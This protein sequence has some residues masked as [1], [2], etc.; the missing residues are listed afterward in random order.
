MTTPPRPP[1]V[2]DGRDPRIAALLQVGPLDEVTRARLVRTALAG[3]DFEEPVPGTQPA[4]ESTPEHTPGRR[5]IV[6]ILSAAAALIVVLVVG[7]A[8]LVPWESDDP[9]PTALDVPSDSAKRTAP[10]VPAAGGSVDV[11]EG[12]VPFESTASGARIS[13][14]DS[15]TLPSL[16]DLGDVSN[17]TRLT[18]AVS[19]RLARP[20]DSTTVTIEGCVTSVAR[21]LGTPVAVGTGTIDGR[22]AVVVVAE[23]P[24]GTTAAVAVR[25]RSCGQAVSAVLP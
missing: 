9:R 21:A 4:P 18:R 5:P 3:A 11:Q 22:R 12:S 14:P 20:D 24:D 16:G 15:L 2:D 13:V 19:T 25:S 6:A 1:E 8:A 10:L 17:G 23:Q 7:L